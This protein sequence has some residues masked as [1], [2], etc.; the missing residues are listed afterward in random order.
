MKIE[1]LLLGLFASF[2]MV[3]CSQNDD[4][5]NVGEE[6]KGKDSYLSIRISS[7][8]PGSRA[9]GE[10]E[11]GVNNKE[12]QV[13]SVLFFFFDKDGN[14][15]N[16]PVPTETTATG[17][18][19]VLENILSNGSKDNYI[20]ASGMTETSFTGDVNEEKV[21][22][23]VVVFKVQ[24]STYPSSVIAVL[25]WDYTGVGLN[26]QALMNKLISEETAIVADTD[27]DNENSKIFVMS[28]SVYKSEDCQT[29]FDAKT[30]SPANFGVSPSDAKTKAIDIHVE[31]L[32]AK[33]NTTI[34]TE[35]TLT[36]TTDIF[37]V[38][39][40]QAN[41]VEGKEIYAKLLNW[42]INTTASH[43]YLVKHLDAAWNSQTTPY[44]GWNDYENKR[45]YYAVAVPENTTVE[46]TS[47]KTKFKSSFKWSNILNSF[48][49]DYTNAD[50]CLENT[51]QTK[52]TNILVKA[53]LGTMEGNTF[54]AQTIYQWYSF[55]FTSL[56]E[57]QDY[58]VEAV[59]DKIDIKSENVAVTSL[60]NSS[61]PDSHQ[62][63]QVK[64]GVASGTYYDKPGGTV[65]TQDQINAIFNPLPAA[66]VWTD[67]AT[68]YFTKILHH[69]DSDDTKDS[70]SVIRNHAYKVSIEGVK[71]LGT[72]VY[73]P[74]NEPGKTPEV[75]EPVVPDEKETYIAAKI[76]VL[77]W[78]IVN[79]SVVL[80]QQ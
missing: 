50:Y 2:L 66:K 69:N 65:L 79:N 22:D 9:N 36:N 51:N 14:A 56:K 64:I 67:G 61:A 6:A 28:N 18:E 33:V 32:A 63:Y 48:G 4:S 17:G 73:Y 1:R 30:V 75:P 59:G 15:F 42:D 40:V 8:M 44:D 39:D 5:P 58:V 62:A 23:A 31:R 46:N 52:P 72:P 68:Y 54:N 11:A 78:K 16:V 76:N 80:G 37:K 26:K 70:Y 25:N 53:Q 71:G 24:N 60:Y 45:S 55:Y 43:S 13:N 77:S 20:K 49:S 10:F 12:N 47:E 35:K 19:E 38:E 74:E 21:L 3:G 27:A 41:I 34:N 7:G 29:T 57:L